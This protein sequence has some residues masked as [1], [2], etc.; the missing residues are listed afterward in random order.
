MDDMDKEPGDIMFDIDGKS[1][2]KLKSPRGWG[3]K[4]RG[5]LNAYPYKCPYGVPGDRLWVRENF[6]IARRYPKGCLP[7]G[8]PLPIRPIRRCK[9]NPIFYCADGKPENSANE[10]YGLSG[11]RGGAIAAPDPYASWHKHPSIHMPRWASRI[12]LKITDVRV[13]RVQDISEVD[14]KAEGADPMPVRFKMPA[15]PEGNTGTHQAG[16]HKLWNSIHGPDAWNR[17]DWVWVLE[18]RSPQGD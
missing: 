11:L 13:E 5:W 10:T 14:A 6:Y 1:L 3:A 18:F 17:N 4:T 9:G 2:L 16:F 15:P 12:T 7:S 8:E